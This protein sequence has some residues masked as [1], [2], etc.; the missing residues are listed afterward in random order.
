MIFC[1]V[2]VCV[3]DFPQT[4]RRQNVREKAQTLQYEA[5][6]N[7]VFVHGQK[8]YRLDCRHRHLLLAHDVMPDPMVHYMQMMRFRLWRLHSPTELM[9]RPL[10]AKFANGWQSINSSDTYLTDFNVRF[11]QH[12]QSRQNR[13]LLEDIGTGDLG[14][15]FDAYVPYR[16]EVIKRLA[17]M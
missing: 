9:V 15:T 8:H 14:V 3:C 13:Q 10:K 4:V 11:I 12:Y 2:C 16:C 6:C 1:L 5:V 17:K 7:Y